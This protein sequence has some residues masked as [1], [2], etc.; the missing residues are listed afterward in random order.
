[1]VDLI[2]REFFDIICEYT[3]KLIAD[4]KINIMIDIVLM[5]RECTTVVN[6]IIFK[7]NPIV[8]GIPPRLHI[9]NAIG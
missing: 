9:F 3:K 1:M 6:T 4:L 2:I 5:D 7:K 8:G